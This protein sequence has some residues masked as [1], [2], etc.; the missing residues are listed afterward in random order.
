MNDKTT[1]SSVNNVSQTYADNR[2]RFP[3]LHNQAKRD[4]V[5][6]YNLH[7]ADGITR[8]ESY[9][10]WINNRVSE[11]KSS[12]PQGSV[13][14]GMTMIDQGFD[15]P[16]SMQP[17]SSPRQE[18]DLQ[19]LPRR[20]SPMQPINVIVKN[21]NSSPPPPLPQKMEKQSSFEDS[22]ASGI[23][24]GVGIIGALV[25]VFV[26]LMICNSGGA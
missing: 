9:M 1:L 3:D 6:K 12:S 16:R 2:A 13:G 4:Y 22:F 18:L 20:Q 26:V 19:E 15:S 24:T 7:D 5:N 8:T 14:V 21:E 25:L 11:L 23:G 17:Y 10:A